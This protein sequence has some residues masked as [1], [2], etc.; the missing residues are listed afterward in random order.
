MTLSLPVPPACD[1]LL[2]QYQ[3]DLIIGQGKSGAVHK[4]TDTV[5]GM[6]YALKKSRCTPAELDEIEILKKINH[7]HV[8]HLET[9]IIH[10][11]E[12]FLLLEL[13]THDLFEEI[14]VGGIDSLQTAQCYFR[15]LMSGIQA[16]H[17]AGFVHRDIKPE[18]C[19]IR[20]RQ[21]TG[22]KELVVGDLDLAIN[23]AAGSTFQRSYASGTLR[24]CAPE[25]V[26]YMICST[27]MDVWSAGIVLYVMCM[28][29]FPFIEPTRSCQNFAAFCRT[30]KLDAHADIERRGRDFSSVIYGALK[31]D[32]RKRLS[33][34]TILKQI[35]HPSILSG[36]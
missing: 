5:T 20:L 18:N 14:E 32:W 1:E 10:Q 9:V 11:Q 27:A 2:G 6:Q 13:C 28:R 30:G 26:Q 19:F 21:E 17:Q 35:W 8:V 31:L 25:V 29:T 24:Y 12:R 7:P 23:C 36:G 4:V 16:I 3:R 33:V 22:K 34:D 15:H